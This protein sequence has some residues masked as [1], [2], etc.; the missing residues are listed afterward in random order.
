[1]LKPMRGELLL[2]QRNLPNSFTRTLRSSTRGLLLRLLLVHL[3]RLPTAEVLHNLRA[4]ERQTL[5]DQNIKGKRPGAATGHN[6]TH[7]VDSGSFKQNL[8]HPS[9]Q[10]VL[11]TGLLREG[12]RGLK[13]A[14]RARPRTP[15]ILS[16]SQK[17]NT[18]GI[19]NRGIA[20]P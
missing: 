12:H 4:L 17:C 5:H 13:R 1:M 11:H 20:R 2:T 14:C 7:L 19:T 6:P 16:G 15:E 9:A 8:E 3:K 10:L 18:N